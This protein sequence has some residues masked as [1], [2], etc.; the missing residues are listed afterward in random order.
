M[1]PKL[2]M[3]RNAFLA[4]AFL[5]AAGLSAGRAEAASAVAVDDI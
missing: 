5:T 4:L 3:K 1:V 2:L